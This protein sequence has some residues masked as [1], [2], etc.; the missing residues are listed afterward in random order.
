MSVYLS[1]IY[2]IYF[3]FILVLYVCVSQ[4]YISIYISVLYVYISA[5]FISALYAC[6]SQC[7]ISVYILVLY[8]YK[9]Q[10][11]IS[12]YLI[13]ICLYIS[14]VHI[15]TTDWDNSQYPHYNQ[16]LIPSSALEKPHYFC[17]HIDK[18]LHRPL[19]IAFPPSPRLAHFTSPSTRAKVLS[20]KTS[21]CP[22][23]EGKQ[24]RTHSPKLTQLL[25]LIFTRGIF[26]S[27]RP[28]AN[29]CVAVKHKKPI[30]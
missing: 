27:S 14:V 21:L 29:N 5:L 6:I 19:S 16:R 3:I 9:P 15:Y 30:I 17:P 23:L 26:T 24:P 10:C 11:Y 12:V 4:C 28:S 13:V 7:Y 8:V 22:W 18:L 2:L 20:D 25:S 1:I